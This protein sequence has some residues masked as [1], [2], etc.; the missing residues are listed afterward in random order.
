MA[1]R[2]QLVR[3]CGRAWLNMVK[4]SW[5][6]PCY[7]EYDIEGRARYQM[8]LIAKLGS[9]AEACGTGQVTATS[10]MMNPYDLLR[11]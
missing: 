8:G 2:L 1:L 5:D 6:M 4:N 10:G 11:A 9:L 3:N 7:V